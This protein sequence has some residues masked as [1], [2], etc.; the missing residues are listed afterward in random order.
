MCKLPDRKRFSNRGL[1]VAAIA[2]LCLTGNLGG[3][4]VMLRPPRRL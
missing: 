4:K 3:V 2:A 1:A